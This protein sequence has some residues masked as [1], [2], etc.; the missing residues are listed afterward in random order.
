MSDNTIVSKVEAIDTVVRQYAQDIDTFRREVDDKMRDLDSA[1]GRLSNAWSGT[2]HD[3]FA[4][5]MRERQTKIRG[6]LRRAGVLKE[7]LHVISSRMA[8]MLEQ[9]RAAGEDL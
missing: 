1:M 7:D 8:A 3:Q 2:L 5:R 9:L 4:D 6:S